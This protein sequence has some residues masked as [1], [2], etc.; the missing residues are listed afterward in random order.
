VLLAE[1]FSYSQ[2]VGATFGTLIHAFFEKVKWLGEYQVDPQILRK[3]A[4]ATITPEE[5]RHVKL[6]QV[7][8]SFQEMLELRSVRTALSSQRYSR[9]F[10][11]VV[12]D[13]VEIDN[14]RMINL[15]VGDR[16]V[17]GTI[18]RLVVLMK[19][20]R[21]YAAEIIDFKTD[22]FDPNMTLLWVQDRIDHHR[23]Q[24]EVYAQVVSQLFSIPLERIGT[25]LLLLSADEFVSCTRMSP[26][27][28]QPAIKTQFLGDRAG[29]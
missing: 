29:V 5:M 16:L 24:L 28:R 19:D 1:A 10:H 25:H 6:D 9:S 11:G 27:L 13:H 12:P 2:S 23:P 21:P 14:E 26:T 18:D 22:A 15:V 8:A 3:I 20:G 7:I 4:L 17:S